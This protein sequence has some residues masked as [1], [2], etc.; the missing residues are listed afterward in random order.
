MYALTRPCWGLRMGKKRR[1]GGSSEKPLRAIRGQGCRGTL[2]AEVAQFELRRVKRNLVAYEMLRVGSKGVSVGKELS[3][4]IK[5][6]LTSKNCPKRKKTVGAFLRDFLK[7]QKWKLRMEPA[8][9]G[10]VFLCCLSPFLPGFCC[11]CISS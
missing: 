7:H 8:S 10:K 2:W 11:V 3:L 5:N 6:S 4:S 1:I 9:Q